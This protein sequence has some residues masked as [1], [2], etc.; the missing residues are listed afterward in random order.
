MNALEIMSIARNRIGLLNETAF[1]TPELL[2]LLEIAQNRV[3]RVIH[4]LYDSQLTRTK[5]YSNMTASYVLLPKDV[6]EISGASRL[7]S[8]G[9]DR[10][11]TILDFSK[12]EDIGVD[13]NYSPSE[14]S[15]YAVRD[16]DNLYFFP[17]LASTTVSV[18]YKR[19]PQ[20]PPVGIYYWIDSD[21]GTL[22]ELA[23]PID[24]LYIDYFV[25]LYQRTD[26]R[27]A[28]GVWTITDYLGSTK[29]IDV[30]ESGVPAV[31]NLEYA[32]HPIIPAHYH[33]VLV[34]G[35]VAE[36]Y[37][38]QDVRKA[39]GIKEEIALAED[40]QFEKR[41]RALINVAE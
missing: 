19:I 25:T 16:G 4:G 6:R 5:I 31:A 8:D 18:K 29:V 1:A 9:I 26:K 2:P 11:C 3:D 23:L 10:P 37:K 33:D 30:K 34:G 12:K 22:G 14:Y 40:S 39:L 24:D 38:S 7:D 27:I 15:P 13:P 17:V 28:K 20:A 21:S 36:L 41:L 35:L 32:L